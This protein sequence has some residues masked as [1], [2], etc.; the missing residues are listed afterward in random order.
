M[1]ADKNDFLESI[2]LNWIEKWSKSV[3]HILRYLKK[4]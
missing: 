4:M 3:E 2:E 1:Y